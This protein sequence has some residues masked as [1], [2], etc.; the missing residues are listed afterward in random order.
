MIA[1]KGFHFCELGSKQLL[2]RDEEYWKYELKRLNLQISSVFEFGHFAHWG[3]RRQ[4]YINHEKLANKLAFLGIP[5]V[6]LGPGIQLSKTMEQEDYARMASQ[7]KET[8]KR[9]TYKG[10]KVAIHPHFGHCIFKLE[11]IEW[12]THSMNSEIYLVPDL[13]HLHLAGINILAFIEHYLHVIAGFHINN[14]KAVQTAVYTMRHT[15]GTSLDDGIIPCAA[16]LNI[17]QRIGFTGGMTMEFE[18]VFEESIECLIDNS[19]RFVEQRKLLSRR[20]DL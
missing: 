20:E 18:N 5:M 10:I 2:L 14:I 4:I 8:I 3:H 12:L 11:D 19:I 1:E 7:I 17:L 6:T 9:Y 13:T 16:I 15:R